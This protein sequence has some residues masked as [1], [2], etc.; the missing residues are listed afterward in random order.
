MLV[1]NVLTLVL[2][3]KTDDGTLPNCLFLVH[4]CLFCNISKIYVL[5]LITCVFHMYI[6]AAVQFKT[7]WRRWTHQEIY[8]WSYFTVRRWSREEL[9]EP[10]WPVCSRPTWTE[11]SQGKERCSKE[12]TVWGRPD[13]TWHWCWCYSCWWWIQETSRPTV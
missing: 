10:L 13:K 8:S 5:N 2:D 1:F 7:L 6:L 3:S 12:S 11:R 9:Q 4:F